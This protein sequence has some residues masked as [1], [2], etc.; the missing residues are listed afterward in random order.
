MRTNYRQNMTHPFIVDLVRSGQHR[1]PETTN[2][3]ARAI[4]D[5]ISSIGDSGAQI[6]LDEQ[7]EEM[8]ELVH[9]VSQ[10]LRIDLHSVIAS[11]KKWYNHRYH[12]AFPPI[13]PSKN[14]ETDVYWAKGGTR[15]ISEAEHDLFDKVSTQ[16]LYTT[17]RMLL[18]DSKG[19]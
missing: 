10:L 14:E 19:E 17:F 9:T 2:I 13:S 8:R 12:V 3:I 16:V 15:F 7:E 6:N 4:A 1:S 5:T 11:V 18:R